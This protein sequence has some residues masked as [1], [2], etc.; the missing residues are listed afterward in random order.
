MDI[1]ISVKEYEAAQGLR[2][3]WQPGSRIEVRSLAGDVVLKANR[4]GLVS[5]ANHL[6][7]LAQEDV[8]AGN[9]VHF[10]DSNALEA[11][12]CSLILEK[13]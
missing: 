7:T 3:T 8:P 10:D 11:G 4:A 6:L 9:H 5:L 2:L 12:S 1:T 13:S